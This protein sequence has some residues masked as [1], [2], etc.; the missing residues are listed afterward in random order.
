MHKNIYILIPVFNEEASIRNV[1]S[2]LQPYFENI[3]AVNDGSTDGTQNILNSLNVI[4]I[5]HPIN[6]GQGA[7]IATGLEFIKSLDGAFAAI[8]FDADGQHSVDDAKNFASEIMKTKVDVIFGS[9]FIEHKKN[10]PIIKRMALQ[11]ITFFANKYS[12]MHLTDTHNGLK[13]IRITCIDSLGINIDGF[14]FESQIIHHV[15]KNN[16]LYKELPTNTLYSEYSKK[17]GQKLSNGLLILED[18]FKARNK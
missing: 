11:V 3:V 7:A 12:D 13:A 9:R 18:L 1:V 2:G 8:T 17:K 14:A 15:N 16:L 10:I 6:L 4:S 5:E